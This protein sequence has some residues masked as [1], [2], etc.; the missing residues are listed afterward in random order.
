M[1]QLRAIVEVAKTRSFASAAA[2]LNLATP[3]VWQQVRGLEKEFDI[4]LVVAEG[5]QVVLTEQGQNLVDLARP[6]VQGFDAIRADFGCTKDSAKSTLSVAAPN[7]ILVYELPETIR[8]YKE[9]HPQVAMNLVDMPSQPCRQ[10]LLDGKVDLAVVGQLDLEDV[11]STL[12][13]EEVTQFPFMLICSPM[14]S[15]GGSESITVSL[16]RDLPLIAPASGTNSRARLDAVLRDGDDDSPLRIV[17]EASTK[18]LLMKYVSMEFGVA[19]AP[20][21]PMFRAQA[22]ALGL[23]KFVDVSHLFGFEH[24]VT[25][26]RR[27]K[28]ETMHQRAFREA[29]VKSY[30]ATKAPGK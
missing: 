18:D 28:H 19:I 6:V 10:Q 1:S 27:H 7:D 8:E 15:F 13:L 17:F 14:S 30:Q 21:S 29:V 11:P 24:I 2:N 9:K 3:S 23:A 4:A 16:L 20:V 26:R 25:L 22:V 12:L 5:Q